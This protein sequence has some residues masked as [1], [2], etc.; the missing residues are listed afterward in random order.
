MPDFLDLGERPKKP[1]EQGLTHVIDVGL[2]VVE[3]EGL[4][5]SASEY[6]DLV[7]LGWGSAYVTSDLRAKLDRYRDAGVP[8]MLGGTLTELAWLQGKVD[9]L[10]RWLEELGI[11]HVEVSSGTVH[12]PDDEKLE[13]IR[14]L[15]DGFTVFAEVGEKDPAALLP[16]Y[17]WVTLIKDALEAGARQVICE[18]RASG[19]AGMYRPDGEARTGL[20]E[21]IAHEVEPARLIFEAP[22]KHQQVWF[23]EHFGAAVNLGN[24]LP[25]DVISLETLRLGLR[26]DTLELFHRRD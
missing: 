17:R 16:P 7:R 20:I 18:G 25:D 8:V 5:A 10:R 23:I 2:T 3:V 14:A 19:D 6:V 21:E 26:A 11:E 4:M 12:I 9:A 24:I 1:R 13:L 15:A 22:Q